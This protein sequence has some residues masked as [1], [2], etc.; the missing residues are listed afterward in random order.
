MSVVSTIPTSRVRVDYVRNQSRLTICESVPPTKLL[1]PKLSK[2]AACVML[3]SYGGGLVQG[4]HARVEVDVASGAGLLLT[5]QANGRVY[6]NDKSLPTRT[7]LEATVGD[8][9]F[10]VYLPDP[11]VPHAGSQLEQRQIWNLRPGAHL[12]AGDW[13]QSGRSDSGEAFAFHAFRSSTEIRLDG[14][15][16]A[17]E[18]FEVRP[19]TASP[20]ATG[21]F[22]G[23]NLSLTL[24]A[25]G[26]GRQLLHDALSPLVDAQK[27][28]TQVPVLPQQSAGSNI[29]F[30]ASLAE[31]D[32]RPLCI[33]RALGRTRGDFADVFT[34]LRRELAHQIWFGADTTALPQ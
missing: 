29:T 5:T 10:L 2:R 16:L 13:F 1:H 25:T 9:A 8:N 30:T 31:L 32:D 33:F 28:R 17:W 18:P 11:T 22:A 3:S 27:E 19:D 12:I 7:D 24:Y 34:A 26:N 14:E 21:R 4:D 20:Q 6:R 15:L 23:A